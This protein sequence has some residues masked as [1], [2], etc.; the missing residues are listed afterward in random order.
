MTH[1]TADQNVYITQTLMDLFKGSELNE[2][3]EIT[4]SVF[5]SKLGCK[6]L[7]KMFSSINVDIA[8]A[9]SLFKLVDV[10]GNGSVDPRALVTGWIRLRGSAKSLDLATLMNE[11]GQYFRHMDRHIMEVHRLVYEHVTN[12]AWDSSASRELTSWPTMAGADR[13]R[14][15]V[16]P[17][18]P[19]RRSSTYMDHF[20]S[21]KSATGLR[22][23]PNFSL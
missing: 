20:S 4:W 21:D 16:Q 18:Q 12:E 19:I 22:M 11:T 15:T 3:G 23:V 10:N 9:K 1:A 2:D 14:V 6:E 13:N 7:R 17:M 5:K 8:D